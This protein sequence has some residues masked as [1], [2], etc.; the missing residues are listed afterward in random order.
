MRLMWQRYGKTEVSYTLADIEKA[1]GDMTGD[2]AFAREFFTRYVRGREVVDYKALLANAGFLLRPAKPGAAFLGNVQ[3]DYT[4]AGARITGSTQIGS[5]LYQAGLDV[6]DVITLIDGQPIE[7]DS[8]FQALKAA[9]QP[10]ASTGRTPPCTVTAS[11]TPGWLQRRNGFTAFSMAIE[12][13][14]VGLPAARRA[15]QRLA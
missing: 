8:A 7:S 4:T 6:G 13:G 11:M 1:L 9:R 3:L 2:R 15:S 12:V 14:K 10:T 5:P